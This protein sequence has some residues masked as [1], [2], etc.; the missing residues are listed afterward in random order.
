M[1]KYLPIVLIVIVLCSLLFSK[2]WINEFLKIDTTYTNPPSQSA[3][4]PLPPP[5]S[6][7]QSNIIHSIDWVL[8]QRKIVPFQEFQI[9]NTNLLA[10]YEN[11]TIKLKWTAKDY[12]KDGVI[13]YVVMVRHLNTGGA[14]YQFAELKYS[15][16]NY[17]SFN[18]R[19]MPAGKYD[20]AV[21]L[22]KKESTNNFITY[23]AQSNIASVEVP[24]TAET[25]PT[26]PD[27]EA[28]LF[29]TGAESFT[30]AGNYNSLLPESYP[31]PDIS[32][33][34]TLTSKGIKISWEDNGA[35]LPA[36]YASYGPIKYEYLYRTTTKN[37][38]TSTKSLVKRQASNDGYVF[39]DK[40]APKTNTR[41]YYKIIAVNKKG[42]PI[43]TSKFIPIESYLE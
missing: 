32:G 18:V 17:S 21:Q 2:N 8:E 20:W 12:S 1:K 36:N 25:S 11:K 31:L 4:F 6:S 39:I 5:P 26:P 19:R 27:D 16:K 10:I 41:Y 43:K 22:E 30:F 24:L 33:N 14:F 28:K 37:I 34:I 35:Y 23:S 9:P 42:L 3:G 29:P 13:G 40:N 7:P 15:D 38:S